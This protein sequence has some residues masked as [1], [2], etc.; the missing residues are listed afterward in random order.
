MYCTPVRQNH[1]RQ[2]VN[3]IY[4]CLSVITNFLAIFGGVCITKE[5][6]AQVGAKTGAMVA[7]ARIGTSALA[8]DVSSP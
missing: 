6:P 4:T 7:V 3:R 2:Y 5:I 8:V 1:V